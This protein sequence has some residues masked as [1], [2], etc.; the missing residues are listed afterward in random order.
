[1]P[2]GRGQW[3]GQFSAK[4]CNLLPLLLV[5]LVVVAQ[6]L[7]KAKLFQRVHQNVCSSWMLE[8]DSRM[9]IKRNRLVNIVYD[10]CEWEPSSVRQTARIA[11]T[12]T[13]LGL[14]H[15]HHFSS[16]TS[17][18]YTREIALATLNNHLVYIHRTYLFHRYIFLLVLLDFK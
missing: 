18:I 14:K 2:R 11:R 10:G 3:G 17:I 13:N 12:T 8:R 4:F 15:T 9:Y 7:M 16:A 1:M 5:V 6:K